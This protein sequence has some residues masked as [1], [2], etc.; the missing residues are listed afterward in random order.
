MQEP[1]G[2]F[3]PANSLETRPGLPICNTV[4]PAERRAEQRIRSRGEVQIVTG[5]HHRIPGAVLD[6]SPGGMSVETSEQLP[7]GLPVS[8]E[9]HGLGSLGVVRRCVR[10]GDQY[11]VGMSLHCPGSGAGVSL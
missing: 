11:H 4:E 6:V 8:I 10:K 9:I 3:Y 2:R 1:G 7:L 5:D